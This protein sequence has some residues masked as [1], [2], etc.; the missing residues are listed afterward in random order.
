MKIPLH[1]VIVRP[2]MTEKATSVEGVYTFF[3]HKDANKVLIR[4]AVETMFSVKVSAVN[5]LNYKPIVRAF[6]RKK[7]V[8]KGYKKA[9]IRVSEGVINFSSL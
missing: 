4:K 9:Y 7:G 3:V 1:Q 8:E 2:I 5:T 6:G